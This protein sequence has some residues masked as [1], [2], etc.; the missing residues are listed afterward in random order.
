M[1]NRMQRRSVL[2]GLAT[3]WGSDR[4]RAVA[5]EPAGAVETSRGECY[6]QTAVQR[7]MLAPAATLFIGDAVGTGV[8]SALSMHLGA[9]TRVKIGAEAQLRID[10][11]VV[12]AGGVLVLERG[13]MLYDHDSTTGQSDVTVRGPYGLVAVRGTRFFAGPSNGVFGVFVEQGTVT[14]VGVSTA[15]TLLAGQGTNIARPGDE[16][17]LPSRWGATRIGSAMASVN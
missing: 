14:V 2:T 17:T 10:R 3:A 16:P 6:A 1:L 5:A 12:N 15:V 13:A 7:R 9:A 8:L 4:A 11:F